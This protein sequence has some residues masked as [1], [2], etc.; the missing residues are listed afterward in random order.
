MPLSQL[1]R[2]ISLHKPKCFASNT[3]RFWKKVA[4]DFYAQHGFTR[5]GS[6][7]YSTLMAFVPL[8]IVMV[9][10]LSFFPFF[11][12]L[13]ASIEAFVFANFVPHTGRV[14]LSYVLDFQKD[15][16]TLPWFSFVFLF[17][18]GIMMLITMETHL[19]ELWQV[20]KPRRFGLSLLIHW[21]II[22]VGPLLL[23]IS[24][25]LSSYIVS[26]QVLLARVVSKAL[27]LSPFICSSLAYTFLYKT[28]PGCHV[29]WRHC[30]TG[31]LFAA[32]LFEAAK[33]AFAFYANVFTTY[34]LLYG[35]LATIPLFLVWLYCAS[36]IF[37]LG[38]QVVN[39]LRKTSTKQNGER[40]S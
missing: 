13:I 40:L 36:M 31:G 22:T 9:S 39:T 19:D 18:T 1:I 21:S 17:A 38:G 6:L 3:Y 15:A 16:K 26:E 34:E 10:I 33:I 2:Q 25:A 28:L 30:F 7:A 20:E 24:L 35:A 11:D 32:L 5:S 14:V 4:T 27:I 12:S 23:C 29:S 37:L 8:T